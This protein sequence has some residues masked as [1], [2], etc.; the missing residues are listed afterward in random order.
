MTAAV[1]SE[2]AAAAAARSLKG[3]VGVIR[4][5]RRERLAVFWLPRGRKR[6]HRPP[7]EA[8]HRC[9]D[10]RTP[11]GEFGEFERCLNGLQRRCYTRKRAACPP[12][13]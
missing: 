13:A 7:M 11:C 9:H 4:H 6:A 3:T 1:C 10:V 2:I 12:T 8:A 5:E